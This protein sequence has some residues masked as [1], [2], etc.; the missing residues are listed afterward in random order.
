M[1]KRANTRIAPAVFSETTI[2][3]ATRLSSRK[4]RRRAGTPEA[5]A[6]F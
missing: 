3:S 5:S 1:S 6:I 4:N 2:V